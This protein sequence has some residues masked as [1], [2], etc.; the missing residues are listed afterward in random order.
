MVGA[1]GD[2]ASLLSARNAAYTVAGAFYRCVVRAV[3]N[4]T[5]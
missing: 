5:V 2:V 1:V 4:N 3:F